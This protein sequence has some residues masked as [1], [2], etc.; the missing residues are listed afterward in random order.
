MPPEAPPPIGVV[1][2]GRTRV[3]MTLAQL[4]SV[5]SSAITCATWDRCDR[6]YRRSAQPLGFQ[7]VA[8]NQNPILVIWR[9][10]LPASE[11]LPLAGIEPAD[12]II[13][14]SRFDGD[15]GCGSRWEVKDVE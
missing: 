8:E 7:S 1:D 13:A 15:V 2:F 3:V 5:S 9:R 4:A 12:R 11:P 14:F 10:K 6:Y